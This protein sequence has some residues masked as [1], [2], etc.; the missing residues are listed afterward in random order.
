M[1]IVPLETGNKQIIDLSYME[2]V[3][4]V[5][6]STRGMNTIQKGYYYFAYSVGV[7]GGWIDNYSDFI[8]PKY[9]DRISLENMA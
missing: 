1:D 2:M 7:I 9:G 5:G 4:T 8:K 6:G 3:Q